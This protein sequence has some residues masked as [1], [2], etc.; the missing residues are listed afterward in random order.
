MVQLPAP[1]AGWYTGGNLA[2]MPQG[3]AQRM[4]NWRPTTTGIAQR[5]GSLTH[6]SITDGLSPTVS[7]ITYNAANNK[8]LFAASETEIFD[9]TT[10]VDPLVPPD[11]DVTGQ[12]S[13]YYSFVNF[14]TSGDEFLTVVNGTDPLLL[15]DPI[16]GWTQVTDVS[17]PSITGASTNTLSFVWVYRNREFFAGP[18]LIAYCL[19]V[20]SVA[21][22]LITIDLNGVFQR[23]GLISFG[24]SWSLDTG[25]GLDD[26]CV[27]VTDQ[28]EVAVFEGSDPSSASEWNLVGRYDLPPTMGPRATM[29]AGGDLLIGTEAGVIPIS[30]V[31]NK[32][33][34]VLDTVSVSKA[35]TPDWLREASAR[36]G[37]PWEIVKWPSKAYAIV[38]L[39]ITTE[40][41]DKRAFVVNTETGAWC[42]YTGW[43]TRCMVLHNDQLYFGTS[44]GRIKVAEVSGA[45]DGEPIYYTCIANPDHFG[46]P[47]VLKTMLQARATFYGATPYIA[48]MSVSMDYRVELPS[49]PNSAG[50]GGSSTSLWDVGLWDRALWD[51]TLATPMVSTD[52]ASLGRTGYVA[53]WQLQITGAQASAPAL[54]LVSIDISFETGA[55]VL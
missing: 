36:R 53:Q 2:A 30:Q 10:V 47:G 5:A 16:D 22:A 41:Q 19:P 25:D 49:P 44:D 52:R 37:L 20:G 23:G 7:L 26:K 51:Q 29:R 14:T 28:G 35:I 32:D 34:S 46:S 6:A 13:G 1:I 31:T 24:G 18:G 50:S 17:T 40:G 12:T 33:V 43:D 38:S 42:S 11:P 54:E 45:D 8:R 55:P 4:E 9:I 21:G 48:S 39:P 3:T 15:Y 27:F